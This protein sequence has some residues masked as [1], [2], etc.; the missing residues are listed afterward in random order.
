M[1]FDEEYLQ[2]KMHWTRPDERI[3]EWLEGVPTG[4]ALDLGAGEGGNSF[5]LAQ[6]GWSVTSVD[7]SPVAV[8]FIEQHSREKGY[9]IETEVADALKYKGEGK[10]DLILLSFMHFS[11]EERGTLFSRLEK[12]LEEG[13]LLVYLG[14]IKTEEELPPGGLLDEF[15]SSE[16]VVEE[17]KSLPSLVV[18]NLGDQVRELPIGIAEG[19][20]V[21]KTASVIVRKERGHV[22]TI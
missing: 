11:K 22:G 10:F 7:F 20:Y 17:M 21:A 1:S 5:W 19:T 14:L 8:Q 16:K 3:I 15:P 18:L 9:S 2:N 12:Q 6:Q 13:G 4:R